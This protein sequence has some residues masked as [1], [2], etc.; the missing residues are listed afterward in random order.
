MLMFDHQLN[1]L[2][3]VLFPVYWYQ[4]EKDELMMTTMILLLIQWLFL[5]SHDLLRDR[6]R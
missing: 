6:I 2:S 5:D 4:N 3:E 1:Y